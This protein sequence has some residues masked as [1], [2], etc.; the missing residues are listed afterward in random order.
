MATDEITLRE[1]IESRL[2][3]LH[4]MMN[5]HFK[6]LETRLDNMNKFREQLNRQ[7]ESFVTREAKDKCREGIHI[8]LN[9]LNTW[10]SNM[11]GM[12]SQR[13]VNVAIFISV[14]GFI[15]AVSTLLIQLLKIGG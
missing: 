10:K 13:S 2:D 4:N 12:A 9:K 5:D 8:E 15:T 11:E 1:Y 14:I 6:S 3:S 7:A